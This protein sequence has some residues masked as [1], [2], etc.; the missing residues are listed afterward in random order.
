MVFSVFFSFRNIIRAT[1]A[2][3]NIDFVLSGG[4]LLLH[5]S[6]V[7]VLLYIENDLSSSRNFTYKLKYFILS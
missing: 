4:L 6:D 1:Y 2:S 7:V 3:S 5:I